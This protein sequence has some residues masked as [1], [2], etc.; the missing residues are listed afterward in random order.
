VNAALVTGNFGF[1]GRHVEAALRERGWDVSGMDVRCGPTFDCR[2]LLQMRDV[3]RFDLVI[4]CAARIG[5]RQGI[6]GDPLGVAVNLDLDQAVLRWAATARPGRL[7][8][9]SS[10]AVY[11]VGLQGPRPAATGRGPAVVGEWAGLS[12]DQAEVDDY[13]GAPDRTYGWAKLVGEALAAELRTSGV[14]VTVLR[15][16]SGYGA[17]QTPDYP[18][19]AFIE[20]ARRR[21]D[22]FVVWGT[23]RQARDWVHVD[24]L[25]A[26]MLAAVD[27]GLDGPVNVC[28]GRATTMTEL[29][30]MVCAAAGYQPEIAPRPEKPAGVAWR[31]GDPTRLRELYTPAVSLEDGIKR[32]LAG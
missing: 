7:V 3:P 21:E 30:R 9:L 5:G 8:Y 25:V 10:S 2:A 16:F 6:E 26:A 29:A 4:H 14:P 24:D 20:R 32:A 28:T 17:D 1:V 13:H 27:A 22:P 18:F 11:P 31:V 23:G 19:R 15:P 12:E